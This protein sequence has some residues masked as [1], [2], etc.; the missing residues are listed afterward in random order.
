MENQDQIREELQGA[1]FELGLGLRPDT[2]L[3]WRFL[4]LCLRTP[5]WGMATIRD[6]MGHLALTRCIK[7]L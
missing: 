1:A 6:K 4:W 3:M 7:M 5:H 2:P